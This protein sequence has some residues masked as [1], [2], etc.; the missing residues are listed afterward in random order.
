[1][2]GG[3]RTL[4]RFQ[5]TGIPAAPRGVP[6]IE[7]TFDIDAN[8][9]VHVAAKDKATNK[10]QKITISNSGGITKEDIERM[11]KDSEAHAEED[12]K[13]R[14]EI[15]T[16]NQ[17]DSMIYSTE[18]TLNENKDKLPKDKVEA[19]E[20]ALAT[21]KKTLETGDVE[22]MKKEIESITQLSHKLAEDM[23]KATQGAAQPGAQASTEGTEPSSG[24]TP[25]RNDDVID[26]E[27]K[28]LN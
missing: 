3:N 15:N 21:G 26:V 10:E 8:G 1:M 28:D 7:V 23:Y 13:K 27:H 9:I 12:K 24:P 14:E 2:A 11:V 25:P 18:K 20:A 5:L 22:A 4:G 17:L 6:Q 16:K 19:L